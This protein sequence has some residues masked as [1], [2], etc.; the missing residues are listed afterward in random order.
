MACSLLRYLPRGYYW[1]NVLQPD[2]GL[3]FRDVEHTD[4][5]PCLLKHR[6][7]MWMWLNIWMV[8]MK[9]AKQSILG[10]QTHC[11]QS[12]TTVPW[13]HA[14]NK[15][16]HSEHGWLRFPGVAMRLLW[17]WWPL[18]TGCQSTYSAPWCKIFVPKGMTEMNPEKNARPQ[19]GRHFGFCVCMRWVFGSAWFLNWRT[20]MKSKTH[21]LYILIISMQVI[22]NAW[23]ACSDHCTQRVNI[24][25]SNPMC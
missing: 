22:Q 14:P 9:L 18:H 12:N 25:P 16:K 3:R 19:L 15:H 13:H 17:Q 20:L 10:T 23:G 21:P 4:F 1:K 5:F 11:D 2:L 24:F 6:T 8:G 7:V